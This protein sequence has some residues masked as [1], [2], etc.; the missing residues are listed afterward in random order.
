MEQSKAKKIFL[1]TMMQYPTR[2]TE[3]F[4]TIMTLAN[5]LSKAE[6]VGFKL[7]PESVEKALK[8]VMAVD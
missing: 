3:N 8:N 4:N 2:A 5:I 7:D 6:A 1:E